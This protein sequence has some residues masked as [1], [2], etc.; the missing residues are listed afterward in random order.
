MKTVP[1]FEHLDEE[2]HVLIEAS[3][4]ES[5]ANSKM[6]LAKQIVIEIIPPEVRMHCSANGLMIVLLGY[7]V[8]TQDFSGLARHNVNS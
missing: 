1:G 4:S 2:M 7:T 5:E 6:Q 8:L 3:G